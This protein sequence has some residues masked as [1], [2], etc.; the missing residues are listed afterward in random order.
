MREAY[1]ELDEA[2]ALIARTVDAED[3]TFRRTLDRGMRLLDEEFGKLPKGATLPGETVFKLYDTYGFP[4]DLTRVIAEERGFTVDEAGFDAEMEKQ[5]GARRVRRL[6]RGGRRRRAQGAR[7]ASSARPG[8]SATRRRRASGQ[9]RRRLRE[10]PDGRVE[11]IADQ[12]PFY[13]ES[14]GQIGDT[15]TIA[16]DEFAL[17]VVDT[18]KTP[19]GLIVAPRA[20]H[21]RQA[22][23]RRRRP[24]SPS[25][26][27]A[28]TRIRAN[29]SATHLLHLALKEVLGSHVAQKGSLVAPDRLRF[30]F[31]HFAPMTDDEKRRVE[32]LVN[33]E[34]RKQRRLGDLGHVVRRGQ[35]VGRGGALRREVRRHACA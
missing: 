21:A 2:K 11:L 18:L 29:H 27:R 7:A 16:S 6:G 28:A 30:D 10:L 14:G 20:R 9:D 24:R 19:G 12:T 34:I 5:R 3:Q 15:G 32:D 17:E 26:T 8:S 1:P 4:V 13:G 23:R 31:A 25:T 22:G 35:E 33:D